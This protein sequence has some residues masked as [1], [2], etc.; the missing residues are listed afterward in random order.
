[1]ILN[2]YNNPLKR[3]DNVLE[4]DYMERNFYNGLAEKY[5]KHFDESLFRYEK[6]EEFPLSHQYFYSLLENVS[7]KKILDCCCGY[8]FTTVKCA[9]YGGLVWGIDISPKMIQLAQK[10]ADF[11]HV[12][13]H[14]ELKVMSVQKMNF[15]DSTFD[16]IV[17]LG[18]LHH[19]NLELA[20]KEIS[21]VLKPHGVAIFLE[22]R[23]P[24]RWLVYLRSLLP[25]KCFESPGGGQLRDQEVK[26]FSQYFDSYRIRYF[27]FLRKF[28]RFP[29]INKFSK[30]LDLIDSTLIKIL[31]F[32]KAFYFT[33]VLEF[34]K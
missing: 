22:P 25:T 1:M 14:V 9:K 15:N 5:L 11:N 4:K 28:A 29:I 13:D 18:A 10:N 3:I 17:G 34:Y 32:L 27:N 16:Y 20:G 12:L 23:I 26:E 7:N 6:N 21:R 19:L 31:P 30:Q 24:F 33:F 2:S 8:G